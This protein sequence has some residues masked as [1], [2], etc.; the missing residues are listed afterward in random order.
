M[1]VCVQA[2]QQ[3]HKTLRLLSFGTCAA[4]DWKELHSSNLRLPQLEELILASEWGGAEPSA[5]SMF[6]NKAGP[7]GF[8]ASRAPG[9]KRIALVKSSTRPSPSG[10]GG[11]NANV[12]VTPNGAWTCSYCTFMN[13]ASVS[14]NS[15]FG[16]PQRPKC[17]MCQKMW[18]PQLSAHLSSGEGKWSRPDQID[19]KCDELEQ[20]YTCVCKAD[21]LLCVLCAFVGLCANVFGFG[22]VASHV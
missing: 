2:L 22:F 14:N 17:G 10:F 16:Q 19:V 5:H 18:Q 4:G 7:L 8:F 21:V 6:R 12:S 20:V 9:L 3:C 1:C 13:N 15:A 11:V